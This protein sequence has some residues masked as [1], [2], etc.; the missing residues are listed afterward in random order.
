ML[1]ITSIVRHRT[2]VDE[3]VNGG[4]IHCHIYPTLNSKQCFH[5][6]PEFLSPELDITTLT[7][8]TPVD[9]LLAGDE[10]VGLEEPAVHPFDIKTLYPNGLECLTAIINQAAE[11]VNDAVIAKSK[12]GGKENYYRITTLTKMFDAQADSERRDQIYRSLKEGDSVNLWVDKESPAMQ[13]GDPKVISVK[14]VKYLSVN[15][16]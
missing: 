5:V 12:V 11:G 14:D 7:V 6:T 2:R 4:K 13:T 10:V 9:L 15:Y 3:I 8:G 1:T 16:R